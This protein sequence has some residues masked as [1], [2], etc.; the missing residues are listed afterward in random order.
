MTAILENFPFSLLTTHIVR[1]IIGTVQRM[2]DNF[3]PYQEWR[4]ER[5]DEATA[6]CGSKVPIPAVSA[7]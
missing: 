4:R 2:Y 3:I 5:P 1:R 6:T 7:R